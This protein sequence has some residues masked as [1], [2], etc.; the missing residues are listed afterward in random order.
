MKKVISF[1]AAA[2]IA[3]LGLFGASV[4]SMT[5]CSSMYSDSTLMPQAKFD[6]AYLE[7]VVLVDQATLSVTDAINLDVLKGNDADNATKAMVAARDGLKLA[8][9]F[10]DPAQGLTKINITTATLTAL[11]LY[12]GY[13]QA[14]QPAK[15]PVK[16]T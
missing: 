8:R 6:K 7:A 15:E 4:L 14:H 13:L 10:T 9:T 5:A 2:Q 16:K 3:V 1:F 12:I 11:Q